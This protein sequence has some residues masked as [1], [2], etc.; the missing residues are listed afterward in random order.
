[1]ST[2]VMD[3]R[4]FNQLASDLYA[5]ANLS[6]SKLNWA[7]LHVLELRQVAPNQVEE[8]IRE[9]VTACYV[10]NV[11]AVN[12]RYRENSTPEPLSFKPA[13]GLNKWTDVQLCKY[14]EC[15][16]YQCAE[17]NRETDET[18][19]KLETLIGHVARAIVS[20]TDRYTEANWDYKAA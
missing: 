20:A 13:S 10:L 2:F 17:G 19:R 7:V 11:N 4:F 14:L 18:Y 1:M 5:Q 12:A 16:S 8:A 6:H 3:E 15:L 9:F